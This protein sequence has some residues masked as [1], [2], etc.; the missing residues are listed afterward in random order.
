ML[1][2][3]DGPIKAS[4]L[5]LV[6][7]VDDE[8]FFRAL[9]NSSDAGKN[10]L[11]I[12]NY[13]GKDNLRNFIRVLPKTSGFGNVKV[14]AVVRDADNDARAA[15]QSISDSMAEIWETVPSENE[16]SV[17]SKFKR[18]H[19]DYDQYGSTNF[20]LG[21]FIVPGMNCNEGELEDLILDSMADS[22]ISECVDK[23]I[24]CLES[25]SVNL[26]KP[27]K[28]KLYTNLSSRPEPGLKL[29]EAITHGY[30]D[31][32]SKVFDEVKKFLM[33]L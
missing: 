30:I 14:L 17:T 4:K 1:H 5:L 9:A 10:D 6:E 33:N 21:L 12:K 32:K 15:C 31:L 13:G 19:E 11:E 25:H 27:S 18:S 29:G 23:H 26:K 16:P 28:T 24:E 7:G 20:S 2:Q 22:D 3:S 8:N